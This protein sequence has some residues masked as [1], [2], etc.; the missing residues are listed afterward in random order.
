MGTF[1]DAGVDDFGGL[2]HRGS[3]A[4]VLRGDGDVRAGNDDMDP[5]EEAGAAMVTLFKAGDDRLDGTLAGDGGEM[6]FQEDFGR[7]GAPI[8]VMLITHFH[9]GPF[10]VGLDTSTNTM[11]GIYS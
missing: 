9:A 2:G 8:M 7:E 6:R 5:G 3:E 4:V 1:L 11:F 10:S